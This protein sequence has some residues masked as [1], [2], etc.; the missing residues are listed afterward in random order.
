MGFFFACAARVLRPCCLYCVDH[1]P[2]YH[3]RFVLT[4]FLT[5][6]QAT[7]WLAQMEGETQDQGRKS[8]QI[9]TNFERVMISP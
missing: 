4:L 5:G 7:F 3:W 8:L 1:T 2:C 9:K 6:S